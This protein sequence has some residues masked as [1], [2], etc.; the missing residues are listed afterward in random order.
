MDYQSITSSNFI[1]VSQST[2]LTAS[3]TPSEETEGKVTVPTASDSLSQATSSQKTYDSN[4]TIEK[5]LMEASLPKTER[6]I[7]IVQ[8]LLRQELSINKYSILDILKLSATFRETS[9]ETLILMKKL[10][11]P[12][13]QQTINQMESFQNNNHSILSQS[14]HLIDSF[15]GF[16]SEESALSEGFHHELLSLFLNDKVEHSIPYQSLLSTHFSNE[17]MQQLTHSLTSMDI[18]EQVVKHL[19]DPSITV[20]EFRELIVKAANDNNLN[21]IDHPELKQLL[22]NTP[23]INTN[24]TL[25]SDVL[26]KNEQENLFLLLSNVLPKEVLASLKDSNDSIYN[27]NDSITNLMKQLLDSGN[28]TSLQNEDSLS[29]T[30]SQGNNIPPSF[31][32]LLKSP[33]YQKLIKSELLSKLTLELKDFTKKEGPTEFYRKLTHDLESLLTFF[34]RNEA[35]TN[36]EAFHQAKEQTQYLRDQIDFMK[37]VNQFLGYVQLP[38]KLTKDLTNS[39]LFF[40]TKRRQKKEGEEN[41]HVLLHLSMTHL[42]EMDIHLRLR[43]KTVHA[44]LSME[45]EES[46]YLV[47]THINQLSDALIEMGYG[48][49]YEFEEM[50]KKQTPMDRLLLKEEEDILYRCYTFDTKA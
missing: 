32:A 5:A 31:N 47:S 36:S 27:F 29:I 35:N 33:E 7:H 15:L 22:S 1:G 38:V 39:E 9:I 20:S 13:T 50:K 12:I 42:G 28:M 25:L 2:T 8:E 24:V 45:R 30:L 46:L 43:N 11:L 10:E 40:Y 4:Y 19:T 21:L 44:T 41:L 18:P 17:E 48:L 14:Q 26:S 16:I 37:S 6:N 49:T 34:E 23:E 3:K